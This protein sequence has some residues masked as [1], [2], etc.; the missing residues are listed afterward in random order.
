MQER[1]NILDEKEMSEI[2]SMSE[3]RNLREVMSVLT[4][5]PLLTKSEYI[6]FM[7]VANRV[8]N[9]MEKEEV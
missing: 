7:A 1:Y 3:C 8:L 4:S 5:A 9:R 6:S 2:I